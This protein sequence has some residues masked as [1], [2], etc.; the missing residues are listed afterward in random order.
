MRANGTAEQDRSAEVV[1]PVR[2]TLP[3]RVAGIEA[4]PGFRL[5]VRF[6]D[7]MIGEVDMAEFLASEDAGAFAPLRDEAIFRRVEVVLGAVTWP[8]G[9]DL[10][11]D[12][13]YRRIKDS[14]IWIVD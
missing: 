1:P 13:M 6:N 7:G 2:P 10:A 5:H 14:G 11:P 12:A 3:W 9:L 8:G 4:L